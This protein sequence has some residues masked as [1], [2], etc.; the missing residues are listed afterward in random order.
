MASRIS[1]GE[2]L[3]DPRWQKKRLYI[4]GRDEFSC[5][6]CGDSKSTL[7]VHHRHYLPARLPWDYPDELLVTLCDPC[8]KEEEDCRE[9]LKDLI[10]SLH[11]WGYFNTDIRDEV[12]RL[13]NVKIQSSK[14]NDEA[15]LPT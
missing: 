10:P 11:Y 7:S 12:N 3:K 6:K 2:L 9:V 8:H 1:Y 13:I 15:V 5:K 14:P 4:M